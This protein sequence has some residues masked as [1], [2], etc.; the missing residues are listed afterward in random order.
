MTDHTQETEG[1][2]G[3]FA[4]QADIGPGAP[5]GH[6]SYVPETQSYRVAGAGTP[7]TP[8]GERFHYVWTR[9]EGD[10]IVHARAA[11]LGDGGASRRAL[12]W[13]VRGS[14]DHGAPAVSA[15][16][17]DAG[18]VHLAIRRAPGRALEA[19]PVG[20]EWAD[21][22]QL[23]R[24]GAD[25]RLRAAR[26]GD[27][28]TVV[29]GGALDLGDAVYVGLFVAGPD[30]EAHFD[31][32]RLVTPA[33]PGWTRGDPPLGSRLEILDTATGDRRIIH[34]SAVPFEAPNWTP[35]GAA[36][37]YNS[38]GRLYRFDLVGGTPEPID[39]GFATRNNNDHVLSFDGTML[40]ISHHSPEDGG[41]AIIYT[42]PTTG[43]TPRRI[44]ARGPSYLHGWSPDG[45]YLVY[46]A[47]RDGSDGDI[48]RIAAEGGEETRLTT[49]P[50]L[51]DGSE[52][53]PDGRYVYFNSVRSGRMQIWRMRPDG[54][55]QEPVTDD[56]YNNWFAHLS[57]DGQQIV[58]ISYG[59]DVAPGDHPPYKHVY[60]RQMP[61]A[62][63]PLRVVAYLYGGQGT[64]NVPSWAP[65]SRRL[66]FVSNSAMPVGGAG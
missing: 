34:S 59:Q 19:L 13:T 31:N 46:T 15:V 24:T 63:G 44:T 40:G 28:F 65:D 64:I 39:T 38:E 7:A 49:A 33:P 35:D 22:L 21:V 3:Q 58:L 25:F 66:A 60:L 45:K 1:P 11:F 56:A 30:A 12:G 5:A 48:Y 8:D 52:Y 29:E 62:G 53:S 42:L 43:G 27:P 57:P 2:L 9:M 32:V 36:L 61:A 26:F 23:E 4:G 37:I 55:A 10:F 41:H 16:R 51:D 18:Q 47:M 17:N 20:A 50:G 14:L 54:S 6:A